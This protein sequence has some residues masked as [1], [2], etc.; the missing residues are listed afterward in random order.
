MKRIAAP[1]PPHPISRTDHQEKIE[2]QIL[3][4]FYG[5][6][7]AYN[8]ERKWQAILPDYI[9]IDLLDYGGDLA[10]RYKLF[11]AQSGGQ[12]FLISALFIFLVFILIV[13]SANYNYL[14]IGSH[15]SL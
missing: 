4:S 3:S 11:A 12:V 6:I 15:P 13:S 10:S 14:V 7:Y 8:A 1:V 2:V 5:I 9:K